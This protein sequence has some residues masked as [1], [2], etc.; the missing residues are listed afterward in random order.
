[1]EEEAIR[2]QKQ[3]LKDVDDDDFGLEDDASDTSESDHQEDKAQTLSTKVQNGVLNVESIDADLN[4][5]PESQKLEAMQRDAP[6]LI[7]M[8]KDLSTCLDEVRQ[9]IGPLFQEVQQGQLSTEEGI[10][11][12]EAKHL[13]LLSYCIN[14]VFYL[15]LKSE[16]KSVRDHP[17]VEK[18][19]KIRAYLERIK[20]LDS[21]LQHQV[22]RLLRAVQMT[23]NNMNGDTKVDPQFVAPNPDNL[24]LKI[25]QKLKQTDEDLGEDEVYRPPKLNPVAIEGEETGEGFEKKNS[26]QRFQERMERR[27]IGQSDTLQMLNRELRGAPEEIGI[28]VAGVGGPVSAN[29]KVLAQRRKLEARENMEEDIMARVPLTKDEKKRLKAAK[30]V[31]RN[32][33]A[34]FDDFADEV[35]DIVAASKA[36]FKL[37]KKQ[38]TQD[39]KDMQPNTLVGGGD[40]PQCET[41]EVR[42]EK[43]NAAHAKHLE[44]Q[45]TAMAGQ[46]RGNEDIEDIEQDLSRQAKR[47]KK[48]ALMMQIQKMSQTHP[49]RPDKTTDGARGINRAIQKNQGLTPYRR[50]DLKNP[51]KKNRLLHQKALRR[52]SGQVQS[53]RSQNTPYEGEKSGIKANVVRGRKLS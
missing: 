2:I 46:K 4:S 21:K 23:S 5:V 19:V 16:G 20:P 17:V 13:L 43:Y 29:L 26:K 24:V 47:Q 52:R 31:S 1:M 33:L 48:R 35:N 37:D 38:P 45:E 32:T 40:N 8:L 50:K 25:P 14:I 7:V 28:D 41:V 53:M 22:E 44:A 49:P 12:L 15:L 10:S 11:Y 6:E 42:R 34:A 27:R 3:N 18:M 30:V 9:K 36:D 51:R 39:V